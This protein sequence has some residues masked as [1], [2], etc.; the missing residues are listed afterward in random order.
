MS[1]EKANEHW[2]TSRVA[3]K[4]SAVEINDADLDFTGSVLACGF[5]ITRVS[6]LLVG[7]DWF[8]PGWIGW[9]CNSVEWLHLPA[10]ATV[11]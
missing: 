3:H 8:R 10:N 1:A 9:V 2:I 7:G 4:R 11:R 5:C 6:F